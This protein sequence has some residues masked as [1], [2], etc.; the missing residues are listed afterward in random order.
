MV[1]NLSVVYLFRNDVAYN[2]SH[3]VFIFK[4]QYDFIENRIRHYKL[5]ESNVFLLLCFSCINTRII[6]VRDCR[7]VVDPFAEIECEVPFIR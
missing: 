6:L 2:S 4:I 1:S 5:A 3:W 7:T